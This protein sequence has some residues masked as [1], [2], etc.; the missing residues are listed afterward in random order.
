MMFFF[1]FNFILSFGHSCNY[2]VIALIIGS[3]SPLN[4]LIYAFFVHFFVLPDYFIPVLATWIFLSAIHNLILNPIIHSSSS[5]VHLFNLLLVKSHLP[6]IIPNRSYSAFHGL[7]HIDSFTAM[8]VSST[9]N[10]LPPQTLCRNLWTTLTLSFRAEWFDK[11][12][13][14]KW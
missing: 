1:A 14:G 5:F 10:S 4:C 3:F 6:Q 8:H 2:F 12:W 13:S 9:A 7:F 11:Q